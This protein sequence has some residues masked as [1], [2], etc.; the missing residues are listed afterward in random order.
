MTPF[1]LKSQNIYSEKATKIEWILDL[2]SNVKRIFKNVAF[3][4]YMNLFQILALHD[5]QF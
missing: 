4:A 3:S 5:S 2:V 1:H